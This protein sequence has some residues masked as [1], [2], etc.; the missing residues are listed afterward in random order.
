VAG[1][2]PHPAD[3][4]RAVQHRDLEVNL[5]QQLGRRQ[6]GN[7]GAH[8]RDPHY[9]PP[10]TT[11]RSSA[12]LLTSPP[13]LPIVLPCDHRDANSDLP[14]AERRTR[15]TCGVAGQLHAVGAAMAARYILRKTGRRRGFPSEY[16]AQ[17]PRSTTAAPTMSTATGTDT[18]RSL[19][20]MLTASAEVMPLRVALH[21]LLP[22]ESNCCVLR[23]VHLTCNIRR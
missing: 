5:T 21:T 13:K 11:P 23:K 9:N 15:E 18:A 1:H 3:I 19:C 12:P 22:S 16:P 20:T 2:T 7:P 14:T 6:T 8:N 4:G 17:Q 10:S